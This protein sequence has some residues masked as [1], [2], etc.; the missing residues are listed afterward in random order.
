MLFNPENNFKR[1]PRST[2]TTHFI[3]KNNSA[4]ELV[5]LSGIFSIVFN[6]TIPSLT[7]KFGE[8][9]TKQVITNSINNIKLNTWY[10]TSVAI[11]TP[12]TYWKDSTYLSIKLFSNGELILD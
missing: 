5:N 9:L 8:G 11:D 12:E 1:I 6:P 3:I 4:G 10:Y 2:I 7:I